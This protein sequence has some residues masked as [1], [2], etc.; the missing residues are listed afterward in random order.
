MAPTPGSYRGG[1]T[2]DGVRPTS[3]P[4]ELF[5]LSRVCDVRGLSMGCIGCV[6]VWNTSMPAACGP[7][8]A[9]AAAAAEPTPRAASALRKNSC[10]EDDDVAPSAKLVVV[11]SGDLRLLRIES[12][13]WATICCAADV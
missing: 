4:S 10:G 12:V 9:A 2:W 3:E 11:D 6:A 7:A 8:A 1:I 5:F 13:S